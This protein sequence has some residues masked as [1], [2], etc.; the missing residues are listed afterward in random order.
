MQD[1]IDLFLP[2]MCRSI[3]YDFESIETVHGVTGNRFA[4]GLRA[5]DNGINFPDNACYN[6]DDDQPSLPSGVMNISVCRYGSPVFMSFPHYF[7]ADSFYVDEVEGLE[8]V[9]EKHESFFVL[10]P[11]SCEFNH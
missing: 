7:A 3:P 9:K 5:V 1:S 2:D 11:V 4:A 6:V 8:P 10:E